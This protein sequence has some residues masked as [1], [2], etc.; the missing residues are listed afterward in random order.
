[1]RK[2]TLAAAP[3]AM[4]NCPECLESVP[5]AAKRCKFCTSAL[6]ALALL[7]CA[8]RAHAQAEPKFTFAKPEEAKAGAPPPPPVEWKAQAKGG[9]VATGGNSQTLN[10]TLAGSVSRKAGNNKFA[11]DAGLAYGDSNILVA[12]ADDPTM[13]MVINRVDR[14]DVVTT[15]TWF[16]RG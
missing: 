10:A 2:S 13:P 11:L 8:G 5:A 16:T 6:A 12:H 1:A 3:A 9:L 14:Q 15:N 7:L 4:K